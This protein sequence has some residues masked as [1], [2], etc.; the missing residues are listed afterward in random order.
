MVIASNQNLWADNAIIEELVYMGYVLS[1]AMQFLNQ[2]KYI[3][4]VYQE[5]L[6][7]QFPDSVVLALSRAKANL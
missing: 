4:L 2:I 3:F 1:F 6:F 7:V 5:R